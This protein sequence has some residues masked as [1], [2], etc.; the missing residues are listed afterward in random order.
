MQFGAA[1]CLFSRRHAEF[2]NYLQE[3]RSRREVQIKAM[4]Y[5]VYTHKQ[6]IE[7]EIGEENNYTN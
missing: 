5:T 6:M 4:Y 3:R 1:G 2:T 7:L